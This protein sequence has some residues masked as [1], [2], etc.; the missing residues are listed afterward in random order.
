MHLHTLGLTPDEIDLHYGFLTSGQMDLILNF[1]PYAM[2][3][4][5]LITIMFHK[6]K[7]FGVIF[8]S[9]VF[10][11]GIPALLLFINLMMFGR[12]ADT[13]YFYN[14]SDYV[15]VGYYTGEAVVSEIDMKYKAPSAGFPEGEPYT[16]VTLDFKNGGTQTLNPHNQ[17]ELKAGD[18]LTIQT[19][20]RLIGKD[21][22]LSTEVN[23]DTLSTQFEAG[24]VTVEVNGEEVKYEHKEN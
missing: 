8:V 3:A 11:A 15:D 22:P 24:T 6:Y 13:D 1:T 5:I 19:E 16:E 10:I 12:N 21:E 2:V 9:A 23:S 20:E 7:W 4:I 18:T 14:N 17:I